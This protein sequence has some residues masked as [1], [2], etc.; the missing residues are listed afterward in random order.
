MSDPT[1]DT[2]AAPL[3]AR[4]RSQER[5]DA[6]LA[7]AAALRHESI[8]SPL[9]WGRSNDGQLHCTYPDA[10]RI[11]LVPGQQSPS[12]VAILGVQMARALSA[13]HG[14]GLVHGAISTDALIQAEELGAQLGRF[15]LFSALC[16]G[17]LG[18]Q[19]AALGL[20]D[21][22]YVA[23]EVQMG[24]VPDERS[25]VFSLGASLYELLTGKPPYGGR[26]TSFVMASV[27]IEK[28]GSDRSSGAVAG[29]VVEALLR[30]IEQA[31]DDRWPTADAFGQALTFG[32]SGEMPVPETKREGWFSAIIRS[33]FPA[34]RSRG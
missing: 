15:G 19:G 8:A 16:D 33:W 5:F 23:P 30:A 4:V 24:K 1:V 11:E 32:A 10:Q 14:A 25:D 12:D 27:L 17:G 22:A 29:L 3:A 21:P 7:R 18:V 2:I 26:T 20:S 28:G 9:E 31:P 34:R 6:A 13:I